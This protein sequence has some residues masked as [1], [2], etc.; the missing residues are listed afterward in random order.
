MALKGSSERST[1]SNIFIFLLYLGLWVFALA[2]L[3]P[4]TIRGFKIYLAFIVLWCC[5]IIWTSYL[6]ITWDIFGDEQSLNGFV[7]IMLYFSHMLGHFAVLMDSWLMVTI[8][9]ELSEHFLEIRNKFH[10]KFRNSY[11]QKASKDQVLYV[12]AGTLLLLM[13]GHGVVIWSIFT[14]STDAK[15]LYWCSL[16]SYLALEFKTMEFLSGLVQ[17]NYFMTTLRQT[18]NELGER[19]LKRVFKLESTASM[20]TTEIIYVLSLKQEEEDE[21]LLRTIK[22]FY[23]E[24]YVLVKQYNGAYSLSLLASTAVYFVDFV[25]NSYWIL[26]AVLSQDRDYFKLL[27]NSST[28]L[29]AFSLLTLM[30]WFSEQSSYEVKKKKINKI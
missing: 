26:L 30:C 8:R 29:K 4:C 25:C 19:N 24:V 23:Y 10:K 12:I 3:P 14:I 7:I 21:K 1:K 2:P 5:E 15:T 9:S 6:A 18:I 16:F 13:C 22:S 11:Q 17:I 27:Q 20:K 28:V